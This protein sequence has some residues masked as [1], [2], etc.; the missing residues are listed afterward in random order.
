LLFI[1][2]LFT[3]VLVSLIQFILILGLVIFPLLLFILLFVVIDVL[4]EVLAH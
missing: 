4:A 1:L 2:A 3:P